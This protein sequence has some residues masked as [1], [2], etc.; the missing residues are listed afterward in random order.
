MALGKQGYPPCHIPDTYFLLLMLSFSYAFNIVS[1]QERANIEKEYAKQLKGWSSKW[2]GVIEKGE[3][4]FL[5]VPV[6]TR[7]QSYLV[8][9]LLI[10]L[11]MLAFQVIQRVIE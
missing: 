9:G 2:L 4:L 7:L 6:P 8:L 3:F 11:V 10:L 5:S 1:V